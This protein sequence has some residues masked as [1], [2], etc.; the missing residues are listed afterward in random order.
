MTVV[1]INLSIKLLK[2]FFSCFFFFSFI[3]LSF[4][5]S[6]LS[7][8]V[9][10]LVATHCTQAHLLSSLTL[11]KKPIA[12]SISTYSKNGQILRP[13]RAGKLLWSH[14][15]PVKH[16]LASSS[17]HA[18]LKVLG[19]SSTGRSRRHLDLGH[20]NRRAYDSLE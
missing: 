18:V 19:T 13:L 16:C 9:A 2:H 14:W 6:C 7:L 4:F 5:F 11:R 12:I 8:L 1:K 20:Q 15:R 10:K 3:I 17:S